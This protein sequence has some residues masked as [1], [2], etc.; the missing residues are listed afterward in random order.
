M[1]LLFPRPAAGQVSSSLCCEIRLPPVNEMG[2]FEVMLAV[3]WA[4]LYSISN[5]ISVV[6]PGA[7]SLQKTSRGPP[8]PLLPGSE[9]CPGF[10]EMLFPLTKTVACP[11]RAEPVG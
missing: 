4:W 6:D 2:T 11:Q 8:V 3:Q 7:G 5:C 9:H 1:L 10:A